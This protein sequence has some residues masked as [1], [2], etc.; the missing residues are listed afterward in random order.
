ME[1]LKRLE[2][3]WLA[4]IVVGA[5]NWGAVGLFG[6]NLV[7]EVLGSG[8]AADVLYV[9]VGLAALAMLPRLAEH[10]TDAG[11]HRAHRA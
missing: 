6:T 4:L 9:L 1:F 2:P 7:A 5:L 8:T 3:V 10:A 11:A